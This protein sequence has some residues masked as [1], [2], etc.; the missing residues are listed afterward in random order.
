LY[1]QEKEREETLLDYCGHG[2]F[3]REDGKGYLSFSADEKGKAQYAFTQVSHCT[4]ERC[5]I[6][7]S[8]AVLL[9]GLGTIPVML[10]VTLILLIQLL[11]RKLKT[12]Y[13]RRYVVGLIIGHAMSAVS[14]LTAVVMEMYM[15]MSYQYEGM[16]ILHVLLLLL[17]IGTMIMISST[18]YGIYL[19][20]SKKVSR[21]IAI[22]I[23]LMGCI[24]LIFISEMAY[25]QMLG[26]HIY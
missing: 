23:G 13:I 26:F 8:K 12:Q 11:R 20:G 7:E 19:A 5:N 25:F 17:I 1:N 2:V 3:S 18:G 9:A 22:L 15:I 14:V 21:K 10:L 6:M 24:Q 16:G 4:Y